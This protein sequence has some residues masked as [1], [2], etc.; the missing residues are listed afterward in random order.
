MKGDARAI[1]G[2]PPHGCNIRVIAAP[3]HHSFTNR[4]TAKSCNTSP[5]S[6]DV[7]DIGDLWTTGAR[8]VYRNMGLVAIRSCWIVHE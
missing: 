5:A 8:D 2:G 1:V 6:V 4:D 3:Q 7:N